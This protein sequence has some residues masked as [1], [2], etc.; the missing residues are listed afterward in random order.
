MIHKIYPNCRIPPSRFMEVWNTA[1]S[2]RLVGKTLGIS[3]AS[4]HRRASD[5]RAQ[6]YQ[7]KSF[8]SGVSRTFICVEINYVERYPFMRLECHCGKTFQ[9]FFRFLKHPTC[10][11]CTRTGDM[12]NLKLGLK[13]APCP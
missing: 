4:A 3:M 7:I 8:H 10:P 2:P 12:V 5:L 13:E 9:F 1:R 11:A 6:G